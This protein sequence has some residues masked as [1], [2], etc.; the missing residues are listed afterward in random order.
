[1]LVYQKDTKVTTVKSMTEM[2][3]EMGFDININQGKYQL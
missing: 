2:K 3:Y 1:M